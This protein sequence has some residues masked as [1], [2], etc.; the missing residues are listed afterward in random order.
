ML[1]PRIVLTPSHRRAS[2]SGIAFLFAS[3]LLT[4]HSATQAGILPVATGYQDSYN[5]NLPEGA[6]PPGQNINNVFIFEWDSS[7]RN[8]DYAYQSL[9]SGHTTLSHIVPFAPNSAFII[10]FI[11][12]VPGAAAGS[13]DAKRHL[14]TL[15]DP[16]YSDFLV[17]NHLGDLFSQIFGQGEQFTIDQM[18]L[19]AQGSQS[20]LDGLWTF[21]TTAMEDAAFDPAGDFRVHKWSPTRPPI[22]VPGSLALLSL[23]SPAWP[24]PRAEKSDKYLAC[25]RVSGRHVPIQYFVDV[26]DRDADPMCADTVRYACTCC[27]F[28]RS[29]NCDLN[30]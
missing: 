11:D 14:Y 28:R 20:A 13:E 23:A 22:P 12:A 7:Q 1:D 29:V 21:V 8:V 24:G 6:T 5:I 18:L 26:E 9:G 3:L 19:A 15:I 10:G 27:G 17:E 30:G 2:L 4:V 25:A 16:G